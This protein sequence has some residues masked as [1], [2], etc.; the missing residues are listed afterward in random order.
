MK[1]Q[2]FAWVR[3]QTGARAIL[4]A[5]LGFCSLLAPWVTHGRHGFPCQRTSL[6][7]TLPHGRYRGRHHLS[8]KL[9]AFTARVTWPLA[10][11]AM[12]VLLVQAACT[13]TQSTPP[14]GSQGDEA[15]ASAI[16]TASPATMP[17]ATALTP[18][19]VERPSGDNPKLGSSL[20]QLLDAYQR[21]GLAEAQ[22]FAET[23]R[24]V[25]EDGR[26]Q[27]VIV[28]TPEAVSDL[29]EAVATLGGEVQGHYETMLQALVPLEALETLARRPDV[30]VIREPRRAGP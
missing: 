17:V 19:H 15:G 24:M 30:D 21:G 13:P 6:C 14:P 27:V 29:Q 5:E 2:A 4:G 18:Q 7:P 11:L 28:T 12:G 3:F 10:L 23:H 8:H 1:K 20:N 16:E 22:A 25:L 26:V 9:A